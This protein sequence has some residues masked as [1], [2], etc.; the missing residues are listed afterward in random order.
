MSR[1]AA[2]LG[3]RAYTMFAGALPAVDARLIAAGRLHDLRSLDASAVDW[4]PRE[5]AEL[6][7]MERALDERGA[8]L[9]SWFAGVIERAARASG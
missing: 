8:E 5:R 9:R 4:S 3:V 6:D 2:L 7:A 1:E